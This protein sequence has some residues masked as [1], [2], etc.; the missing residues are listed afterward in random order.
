MPN[1]TPWINNMNP[2]MCNAIRQVVDMI[3]KDN[4]ERRAEI[5]KELEDRLRPKEKTDEA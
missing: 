5:L 3:F 2:S 4:P 1:F